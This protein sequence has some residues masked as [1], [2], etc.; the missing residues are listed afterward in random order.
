VTREAARQWT[1]DLAAKY[2]PGE[3]DGYKAFLELVSDACPPGGIV[4]DL[5]CGDEDFLTFLLERGARI[6][7]VDDLAFEGNYDSYLRADLERELPQEPQTLDLVASKFLLE[8]IADP[9]GF[10][11]RIYTALK[12]GGSVILMTP[13]ILY[14]PYAANYLLSRFLPQELRMRLVSQITGRRDADIFPVAYACNTPAR[15]RRSLENAGFEVVFLKTCNDILVSAISR[16]LGVLAVAYEKLVNLAG[17][18]G[19]KGF[20]IARGRK[21]GAD[22]NA[23]D[24]HL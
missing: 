1:S 7:G 24:P 6:T 18:K 16:P 4:A 5:G 9:D 23:N 2:L 11:R 21:G 19:V 10:L 22:R 12:P 13:N 8:H 3:A 14:Y 20:I 15:L 17:I